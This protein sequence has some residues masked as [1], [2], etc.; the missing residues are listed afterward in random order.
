MTDLRDPWARYVPGALA[1]WN[2]ERVV[3]LHR[4]AG[5][6]ATWDEIRRD[7]ADGSEPSIGRLLSGVMHDMRTPLTVISGYVQLMATAAD[8]ALNTSS[9][10]NISPGNASCSARAMA[11]SPLAKHSQSNRFF[12]CQRI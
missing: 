12:W 10:E 1:P 5:F 2:L 8:P 3:R 11:C 4:R 9:I 7:L 6:A